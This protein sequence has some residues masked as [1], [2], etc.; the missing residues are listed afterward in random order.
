MKKKQF[1]LNCTSQLAKESISQNKTQRCNVQITAKLFLVSFLFIHNNVPRYFSLLSCW[2]V[3]VT[4]GSIN[5]YS[6][7]FCYTPSWLLQCY[8]I[9]DQ[10]LH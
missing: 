9:F 10:V 3:L 1:E 2:S 8:V 6:Q 5:K 7:S 4:I